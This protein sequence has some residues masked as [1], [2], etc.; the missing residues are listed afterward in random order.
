M[1]AEDDDGDVGDVDLAAFALLHRA[2]VEEFRPVVVA[3]VV[4]DVVA[5]VVAPSNQ[6]QPEM[7]PQGSTPTWG[8]DLNWVSAF[9]RRRRQAAAA[10]AL[11]RGGRC[12]V[13]DLPEPEPEPE[14]RFSNF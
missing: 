8:V 3:E 14:P 5:E 2:A 13:P 7:E 11:A 10:Q 1:F 4:A 6:H 9:R 12:M